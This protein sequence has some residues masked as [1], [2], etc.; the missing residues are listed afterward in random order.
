M[1]RL[2]KEQR[3]GLACGN[4]SRTS[5]GTPSAGKDDRQVIFRNQNQPGDHN[6]QGHTPSKNLDRSSVHEVAQDFIKHH[7]SPGCAGGKSCRRVA[8]ATASHDQR[9]RGVGTSQLTT[10]QQARVEK[11]YHYAMKQARWYHHCYGGLLDDWRSEASE[12]LC[13]AAL[14]FDE[15][16]PSYTGVANFLA[17]LWH[18]LRAHLNQYKRTQA[19]GG[20]RGVPRKLELVQHSVK[21]ITI[22]ERDQ[23][24]LEN[25]EML[26]A[27]REQLDARE[28]MVLDWRYGQD[29]T[30]ESVGVRVGLTKER[31]R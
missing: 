15:S 14:K 5:N 27:M 28:N 18:R 1:E 22:E 9:Q 29:E 12:A 21:E 24:E 6:R 4:V 8:S 2:L 19:N 31:V 26:L 3:S 23:I 11:W 13:V 25:R 30:L 20:M 17:C 7:G 16:R 10:E